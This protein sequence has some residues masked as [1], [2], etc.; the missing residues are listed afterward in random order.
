M[1]AFK[2][3]AGVRPQC[4]RDRLWGYGLGSLHRAY[5]GMST[6]PRK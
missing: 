3:G 5:G 1:A 2:L 4:E 6:G